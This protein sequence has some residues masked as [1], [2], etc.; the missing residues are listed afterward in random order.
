[1]KRALHALRH[2]RR[3]ICR[4]HRAI[5]QTARYCSAEVTHLV[6]SPFSIKLDPSR[7]FGIFKNMRLRQRQSTCCTLYSQVCTAEL[8]DGQQCLDL[9]SVPQWQIC[10]ASSCSIDVYYNNI[11]ILGQEC[12]TRDVGAVSDWR[13]KDDVR[14]I[15][16]E[17]RLYDFVQL[18]F[19]PNRS[20]LPREPLLNCRVIYHLNLIYSGGSADKNI[21]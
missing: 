4:Q 14:P 18:V 13:R 19:R 2:L 10:I 1:M 15:G 12:I 16:S 6:Y 7:S 8:G 3:T 20:E 9:I 11:G 5:C 17:L 21:I